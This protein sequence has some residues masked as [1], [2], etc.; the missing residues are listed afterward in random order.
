MQFTFKLCIILIIFFSYFIFVNFLCSSY[1]ERF[2]GFIT[3][4][5]TTNF[6]QTSNLNNINILR[7]YLSDSNSLIKN[8]SLGKTLDEK[9][10]NFY[11]FEL[12]NN[13][14][15][16]KYLKTL[17]SDFYLNYLRISN[18]ALCPQIKNSLN[19]YLSQVNLTCETF[20]YN[21]TTNGL[22]VLSTNFIEEIR[23]IKFN[24]DIKRIKQKENFEVLKVFVEKYFEETIQIGSISSQKENEKNEILNFLGDFVYNNY[25]NLDKGNTKYLIEEKLKRIC[26]EV[27]SDKNFEEL[28]SFSDNEIYL[29]IKSGNF[30]IDALSGFGIFNEAALNDINIIDNFVIKPAYSFI[31]KSLITNMQT[32]IEFYSLIF[33]GSFGLFMFIVICFYI[34]DWKPFVNELDSTV[35]IKKFL[36]IIYLFFIF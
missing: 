1:L 22:N 7:E 5:N 21:S 3:F 34:F 13:K 18:N 6:M 19:N 31:N 14:I 10:N 30:S 32:I 33:T 23:Q 28:N 4:Y 11:E 2:S 36:I 29:S 9:I 25:T 27:L 17:P 26:A 8:E 20:M 16:K 12:E 35:I 24:F 15:L